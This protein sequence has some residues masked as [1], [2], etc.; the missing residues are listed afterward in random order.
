[1]VSIDLAIRG[2]I[3]YGRAGL[4]AEVEKYPVA[5]AVARQPDLLQQ[6]LGKDRYGATTSFVLCLE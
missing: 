1:M 2:L 4:H 3:G 5:L 6:Y